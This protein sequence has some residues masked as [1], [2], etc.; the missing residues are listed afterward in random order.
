MIDEMLFSEVKIAHTAL[1]GYFRQK[2]HLAFSAN[3]PKA[4]PKHTKIMSSKAK[5]TVLHILTAISNFNNSQITS[6]YHMIV[7]I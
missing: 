7:I 1:L 6:I 5:F 2:Y 4:Q 3:K